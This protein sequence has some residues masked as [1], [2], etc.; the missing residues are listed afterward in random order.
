MARRR[1]PM[2]EF[3]LERTPRRGFLGRLAA[4]TLALAA[5]GLATARAESAPASRANAPWDDSWQTKIKGKHRQVFDGMEINSGFG[6][7]MTR[8]WFMTN[9]EAYNLPEKDLSAVVILRHA[10]FPI[11]LNDAMWAK[12]K[13]GEMFNVT[14]PG[15]KQPAER[16]I[17]AW[18]KDFAIPPFA[19]SAVDALVASGAQPCACN[20]ALM[21]FATQV[22]EKTSQTKE[23]VIKEWQGSLLPGVTLVPSG[24]LA[25]GRAQD[26]ECRYCNVT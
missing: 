15:T 16:N 21:H 13:L 10:A 20:M 5:S 18:Q 4:G 26:H 2:D 14:D 1:I 7:V 19:T 22:A 11:A 12:Y 3:G 6:L 23:A 8:I 24:V 25:V 17:F 9:K